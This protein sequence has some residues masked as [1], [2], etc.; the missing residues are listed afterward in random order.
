MFFSSHSHYIYIYY[1]LLRF[2]A[3]TLTTLHGVEVRGSY[4]NRNILITFLNSLFYSMNIYICLDFRRCGVFNRLC[5]N[6]LKY[7]C[8]HWIHRVMSSILHF[9]FF[10][11]CHT[12]K[13]EQTA[14]FKD[15]KIQF[16]SWNLKERK[17]KKTRKK[18]VW[19]SRAYYIFKVNKFFQCIRW[20]STNAKDKSS[21]KCERLHKKKI[22]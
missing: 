5:S 13:W 11:I 2:F 6:F 22:T 9:F 4:G 14:T 17:K 1:F 16:V 15:S 10:F 7:F 19:G 3:R 20:N 12:K 8:L 21:V 18:Q